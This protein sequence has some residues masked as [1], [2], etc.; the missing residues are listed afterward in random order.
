[1][2]PALSILIVNWNTRDL[3]RQCL[4]SIERATDGLRVEVIV[5]DNGSADGSTEMTAAEFPGVQLIR[6]EQNLGF[7][8]ANNAAALASTGRRLLFLNSDTI[9]GRESLRELLAFM[10]LN[11]D[12]GMVGPRLIG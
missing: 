5:V 12:V 9:V 11:P 3:L 10:R 1:M 8:R 6:N 7:A 4:A 2:S